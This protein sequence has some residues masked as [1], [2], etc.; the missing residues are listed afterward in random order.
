VRAELVAA[1]Y[2]KLAPADH[3]NIIPNNIPYLR[4]LWYENLRYHSTA[5]SIREVLNPTPLPSSSAL[6]STYNLKAGSMVVIPSSLVHGDERR[7]PKPDEF[8]IK[9]FLPKELGG[10][11]EDPKVGMRPFGGGVS[12]CP[13]RVFAEKQVLGTLAGL[14]MRYDMEVVEGQG[15]FPPNVDF[16][17][18]IAM[19][20]VKIAFRKRKV[21]A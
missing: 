2:D 4:S 14:A 21:E 9:R 3:I 15:Q 13:G 20:P 6:N 16:E 12:Q 7:H 18:V 19:K 5:L 1:G 17:V 8:R 11:G 10:D